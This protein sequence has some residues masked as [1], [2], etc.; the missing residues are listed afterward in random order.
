MSLLPSFSGNSPANRS[1]RGTAIE[2]LTFTSVFL[3][4]IVFAAIL[5]I[6]Q[7]GPLF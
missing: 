5:T 1:E 7:G 4:L 3:I 6:L 2:F